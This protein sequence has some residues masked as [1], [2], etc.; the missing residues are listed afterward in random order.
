M[1]AKFISKAL[2]LSVSV[3]LAFSS[4]AL[5]YASN[6]TPSTPESRAKVTPYIIPGRNPGGNR[7]CSEVGQAFFGD[8][9]YYQYSTNRIDSGDIYGGNS[10]SLPYGLTLSTDGTYLS[11]S[12]SFSMGAVIVKGG[13]AAN[14]YV[15]DPQRFSDSGLAAP[16][17][18]GGRRAGLSNVTFCWNPDKP[19]P[20]DDS[21][22]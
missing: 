13:P 19:D 8:P 15:Y 5:V 7:T 20:D 17:N 14:I 2:I 10:T 9:N 4:S 12:S 22:K 21:D 16:I 18:R 1:K 11:F 3:G 6:K